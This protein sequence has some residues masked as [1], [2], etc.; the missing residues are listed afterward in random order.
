M[1]LRNKKNLDEVC[2]LLHQNFHHE[3]LEPHQTV[4]QKNKLT[5]ANQKPPPN[6]SDG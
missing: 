3:K 6:F 4:A 5:P 1:Q 2:S